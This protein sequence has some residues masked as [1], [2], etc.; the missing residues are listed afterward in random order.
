[1]QPVRAVCYGLGP[2]GLGIARLAHARRGIEIVGA[3]DR[4]PQKIGRDLGDLIGAASTGVV[5]HADLAPCLAA[6][7]TL[8]LHATGSSLKQVAAQLHECVAAG[9]HGISTCEELSYPWAVQPQLAAELDAAAHRHGVTLLGTGINP[10]FAMDVLP[11]TL[12]AP[13][14]EVRAVRVVRVVDA[15]RRR[16]P[17]QHKVG[18]GLSADA[19]AARV[20]DGSV[21]HVGLLESLQMIA[22]TLGWRLDHGDEVIQPVIAQRR[23]TTDVVEVVPGQIAGVHQIARGYQGDHEVITLDLKMYV[24]AEDP[25][26]TIEID[27]DPPVRMTIPGGLHGDL[28]TA[29]LVVNTIPRVIAAPPGL[30]SMSDLPLV[31]YW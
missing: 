27:G 1:M 2:I 4:D 13:C 3:V 30:L 9:L 8:V 29:A 24:G 22:T 10:G 28:A 25:Q 23:V 31:H 19:F 12:T 15:A 11:L 20:H 21:R 6:Q 18:A 26:D 14:V 16:G 7:P 17:L 5:V